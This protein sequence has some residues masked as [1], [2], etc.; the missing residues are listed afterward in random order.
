MKSKL[1][2]YLDSSDYS[3][4]SDARVPEAARH[5]RLTALFGARDRGDIE[6]TFSAVT[7]SEISPTTRQAVPDGCRR[8]DLL[9]EICGKNAL[10][11]ISDITHDE[12]AGKA[13]IAIS[14]AGLWAP[15][16]D[17]VE[18]MRSLKKEI[19]E[20]AIGKGRKM[21]RALLTADAQ[22]VK[23]PRKFVLS[24]DFRTAVVERYPVLNSAVADIARYLGG[25]TN[26]R[27][28]ADSVFNGFSDLYSFARM[29]ESNFDEASKLCNWVRQQGPAHVTRI[30]G[31]RPKVAEM[32]S[33]LADST[34][35]ALFDQG[36]EAA[37]VDAAS[38]F[39]GESIGREPD[40]PF[41][42]AADVHKR[43][44]TLFAWF[45]SGARI[46]RQ[47]ALPPKGAI[48]PQPS[49]MGDIGHCAYLPHV[50]VFRCDR[51]T[52]MCIEPV[53]SLFGTRVI[54]D[55]DDLINLLRSPFP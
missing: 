23:D 25:K 15:V 39:Y 4:L 52:A 7:V 41:H 40:V 12:L 18:S 38:K 9:R 11:F 55:L 6:F 16:I 10:R 20:M 35:E 48:G 30:M 13:A 24:E 8:L 1:R 32:R 43:V 51:R 50:D 33:V 28:A 34:I 53:A 17:T 14:D 3:V 54:S 44:P 31:M 19:I 47:Q 45:S 46:M 36:Q 2:V 26:A 5:A 21:R 42:S 49:D 22:H 29:F 27:V 37:L